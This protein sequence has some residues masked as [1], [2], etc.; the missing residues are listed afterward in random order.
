M[1]TF[2]TIVFAACL[3]GSVWADTYLEHWN[4]STLRDGKQVGEMFTWWAS[5]DL[6]D[7]LLKSDPLATPKFFMSQAAT[8]AA[9]AY[10]KE[11]VAS[12]NAHG[13]NAD[14]SR[15]QIVAFGYREV[16][17]RS[18]QLH[19]EEPTGKWLRY[20]EYGAGL[21]SMAV[22]VYLL[23]DDSVLQPK[24]EPLKDK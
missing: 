17:R 4:W 23:P 8:D 3:S 5:N 13:L 21:G 18:D 24:I 20:L 10:M 2:L 19:G 7:S 6:H 12:Y 22:K 15:Y 1:K 9:T 16:P 14:F 11:R